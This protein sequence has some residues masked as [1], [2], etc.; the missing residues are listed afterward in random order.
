VCH[1][2]SSVCQKKLRA[3]VGEMVCLSLGEKYACLGFGV[4]NLAC[5]FVDE[6]LQLS[7]FFHSTFID[8]SILQSTVIQKATFCPLTF[9]SKL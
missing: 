9:P 1:L 2:P 4:P 5:S 3:H 7:T 8:A 6:E